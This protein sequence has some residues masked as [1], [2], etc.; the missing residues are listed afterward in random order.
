MKDF[1]QKIED[2]PKDEG[3]STK[4][5]VDAKAKQAKEFAAERSKEVAA[6]SCVIATAIADVCRA[7][8]RTISEYRGLLMSLVA[9]VF[10]GFLVKHEIKQSSDIH[11]L[12]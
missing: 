12:T 1:E 6:L 10:V 4:E 3:P 11:S 8:Q 2:K 7:T 5:F 9:M